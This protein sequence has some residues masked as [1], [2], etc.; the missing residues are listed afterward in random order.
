VLGDLVT[1]GRHAEEIM[2]M[3][4]VVKPAPSNAIPSAI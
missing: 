2:Q 4:I 3:N 1:T